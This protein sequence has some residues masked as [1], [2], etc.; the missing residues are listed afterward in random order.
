MRHNAKLAVIISTGAAAAIGG[1]LAAGPVA[2]AAGGNTTATTGIGT[3][4]RMMGTGAGAYGG[5]SMMGANGSA[6]GA[7][8]MGGGTAGMMGAG[9][10][11]SGMMSQNGI[12]MMGGIAVTAPSGSL[13]A[14]QKATLAAVAE[15]QQLAHDLYQAF[16][17]RYDN[18]MFDHL[19]D[20]ATYQLD[21]VRTLLT[22]YGIADPT[23]SRN[24]GS[25]SD[26]AAQATYNRLLAQGQAGYNDAL[27][28]AGSLQAAHTTTLTGDLTALSAP[29]VRQVYT[30]LLANAEMYQAMFAQL[31][32]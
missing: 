20:A 11:A 8:M 15:Q 17:T 4:S 7:G 18:M 26:P 21:A 27:H 23:A 32:R 2:A 13:S 10:G 16:A 25:F 29:D 12:G 31:V 24:A 14:A 19:A 28:A 6:S 22:R 5:S 30:R 3:Y 1:V 9:T